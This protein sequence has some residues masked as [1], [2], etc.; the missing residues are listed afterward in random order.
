MRWLLVGLSLSLH[1]CADASTA[2]T[3]EPELGSASEELTVELTRRALA[4]P[5]ASS[6]NLPAGIAGDNLVLFVGVPLEGRVAAI[7]RVGNLSLGELPAPPEGFVLP[8]MMHQIGPR[9]VAV[10]DAGGLPSPRPFVPATPHIYEYS[11]GLEGGFHA[12]LERTIS[13]AEESIGFAEDIASLGDGRYVLSDAI[14]GALWVV[15]SDGS[16]VPGVRAE[17][18]APGTGIEELRMCPS[19]PLIEVGGVP[20]LFS[21]ST[22]PGVSP[23]AVRGGRL[24]FY[25]PCAEGLYS[26]PVDSLFDE[27]TPEARAADICLVSPKPQGVVVEQLL[28]LA[29][30]PNRPEES[31]LY[32]ADSLQLRMIRIHVETGK[33]ELLA[34]DPELFNFPSSTAFLPAIFGHSELLVV[35]NQQQLTPLTNDAAQEDEFQLPF[36]I[37]EL[38]LRHRRRGPLL[39][40]LLAR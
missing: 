3:R 32:A 4:F 40:A 30:D 23:L 18:P 15:E 14:L 29:F 8:F 16:V 7:S 5:I 25:S 39:Q 13:F 33:R 35:S 37:T 22:L 24:Y 38:A 26:L 34:D 6:E 17:N 12:R 31:F 21:G 36:L 20:F 19:M 9:R 2:D 10:L 11:Y 27:R 1:A 28:G